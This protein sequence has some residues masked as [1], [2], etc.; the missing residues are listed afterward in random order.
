M[1][2]LSGLNHQ[3]IAVNLKCDP[4]KS[5][6]LRDQYPDIIAGFHMNKRHWNTI[7]LEGNLPNKFIEELVDHSYNLVVKGLT[8][9]RQ[10][11]LGFI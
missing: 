4:E 10:K 9:K 6:E 3:P 7:S 1:F 11:E 8:K 5:L 2:A